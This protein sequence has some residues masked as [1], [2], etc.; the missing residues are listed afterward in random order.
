MRVVELEFYP[1][2]SLS[3]YV[4]ISA[5]SARPQGCEAKTATIA[6]YLGLS[7][8]SLE[9]G[10]A[11]LTARGPD[12]VVEVSTVRRTRPGGRGMSAVRRVRPM[13]ARER[14]VWL[15]VAAAEDLTPV[16][17]RAYAVIAYAQAR[18]IAL[19]LNELAGYLRHHS[20]RR[21]GQPITADA[22]GR[23][24]DAVEA[25]GWITVHR[26]AG[27]Y[28]RHVYI[29]H[30]IALD[31]TASTVT[32]PDDT[33]HPI[34]AATSAA[35]EINPT[36]EP[37][38]T[39]PGKTTLDASPSTRPGGGSGPRS[40]EGSLAYRDS[41]RTD[42]PDEDAVASCSSAA[43]DLTPVGAREPKSRP[44]KTTSDVCD[45][46]R[47]DENHR[48][49]RSEIRHKRHP[50]GGVRPTMSPAV[51]A[52]LEP[53]RPLLTR[54]TST[55]LLRKINQEV[56]RQL[57]IGMD[58]ERLRHRLIVRSGLTPPQDIRDPG[59]WLL[60]AALPRWG[61]GHWDCETSTMW[62]TGRPCE[63]CAE[64]IAQ[65]RHDT[66]SA[67][68][69]AHRPDPPGPPRGRCAVCDAAIYLL[70]HA[71]TDHLC[72]NCRKEHADN[73][74]VTPDVGLPP[75][76]V[77]PGPRLGEGNRGRSALPR[78]PDGLPDVGRMTR[79]QLD[80]MRR[81]AER[82]PRLRVVQTMADPTCGGP[83][84]ARALYGDR[85]VDL[86]LHLATSTTLRQAGAGAE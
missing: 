9:R 40:G 69:P 10:L 54:I 73:G 2:V 11:K 47:A 57:G 77:L 37:A 86:A 56:E 5:L 66:R 44:R 28:G 22:A 24:V 1:D 59:R 64:I 83:D 14:Y 8:G 12:G 39:V 19:T 41:P 6:K 78:R 16:Q 65:Q 62:P 75:A 48:P 63:T 68:A 71:L 55:F 51:H 49:I 35:V 46:L 29:A 17:L 3:S 33:V 38:G 21:A 50:N 45:A 82:D 58:T 27:A 25:A 60:G 43:G 13:S 34:N 7:K 4:K 76:C 53:V 74:G 67:T 31:P 85:L 30:D 32:R 20:G 70:G 80:D 18:G 79:E 52:V 15:P 23:I 84:Y 72:P 42:S 61:C 26:R 81:K 36:T